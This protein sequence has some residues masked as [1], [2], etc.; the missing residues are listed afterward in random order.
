MKDRERTSATRAGIRAARVGGAADGVR[1]GRTATA[2]TGMMGLVLVLCLAPAEAQTGPTGQGG[3]PMGPVRLGPPV[4]V[5]EL[6]PPPQQTTPVQTAPVQTAPVQAAPVQIAPPQSRNQSAAIPPPE[7]S[8]PSTDR[9]RQGP[10]PAPSTPGTGGMQPESPSLVEP[11]TLGKIPADFEVHGELVLVSGQLEGFN[12]T[13]GF[14]RRP[15]RD[16]LL[17]WYEHHRLARSLGRMRGIYELGVELG[18]EGPCTVEQHQS[19]VG[20]WEALLGR[21]RAYVEQYR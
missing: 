9:E 5:E 18:R 2:L 20:Y 17:E 1:T 14:G 10:G 21:T 3:G 13:C 15:N 16:E 19:L 7:L 6:P 12:E 8:A 11:G 4:Q